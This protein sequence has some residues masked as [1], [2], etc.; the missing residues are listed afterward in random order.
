M[1]TIFKISVYEF[2]VII[3]SVIGGCFALFQ[4]RSSYKLKRAELVKETSSKIREDKEIVNVLYKLDYNDEEWYNAE[5]FEHNHDY[6]A[7]FDRTFAFF[8]Y[9]CYLKNK[10][11]LGNKEFKIF[12]Y[13]IHRMAC[14]KSFVNYM[15]NLY[16][17]SEKNNNP[18]SFYHLLTYMKKHKLLDNDFWDVNSK[19]YK[20]FLNI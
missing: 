2:I 1:D 13:R 20:K 15:F 19:K 6:E 5:F 12:Q 9:L 14:N 17:F 18:I 11:I 7:K 4:W 8:D 16:H 3:L 10:K